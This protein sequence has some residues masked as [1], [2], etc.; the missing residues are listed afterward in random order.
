MSETRPT[1]HRGAGASGWIF[2]TATCSLLS[3][4][5]ITVAGDP[6]IKER[7]LKGMKVGDKTVK[8][9]LDGYNFVRF[10]KGETDK[11]P[12]RR[13]LVM[14]ALSSGAGK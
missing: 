3:L 11:G 5:S 7:L 13:F 14:E 1:K 4:V 8:A 2:I 10:C 9:H 6:K 12:W